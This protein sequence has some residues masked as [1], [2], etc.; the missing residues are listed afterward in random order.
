MNST[1]FGVGRLPS[2]SCATLFRSQIS[3][4]LINVMRKTM[5]LGMNTMQTKIFNGALSKPIPTMVARPR[6][7][8]HLFME[9][10]FTESSR[11]GCVMWWRE[12][13]HI[14]AIGSSVIPT[15]VC[16]EEVPILGSA[17]TSR[18]RITCFLQIE[19]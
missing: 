8:L 11:G 9:D 17:Q 18:S 14:P 16:N 10:H 13:G 19:T 15:R 4:S 2:R 7:K 6:V 3:G 5:E 12:I 1:Q